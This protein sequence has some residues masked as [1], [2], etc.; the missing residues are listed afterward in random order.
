MHL[1]APLISTVSVLLTLVGATPAAATF[2]GANG[3][4]VFV[5]SRDGTNTNLY[6][7]HLDG[8]GLAPVTRDTDVRNDQPDWSPDGT[9]LAFI[10]NVDSGTLGKYDIYAVQTDGNELAR[11]TNTTSSAG[12]VWSPDGSKLAFGTYRDGNYDIYTMNADGSAPTNITQSASDEVYVTWSP[13][14]EEMAFASN[15]D[16]IPTDPPAQ[17]LDTLD[18]Y[19]MRADGTN[20]RRLTDNT[21]MDTAPDWSPDGRKLAFMRGGAGGWDDVYTLTLSTRGVTRLTHVDGF[22]ENPVWSPDGTQIA[23]DSGR[24]GPAQIYTMNADGSGQTVRT[25]IGEN[26]NPDWQRGVAPTA[27]FTSSLPSA[28]KGQTVIFDGSPSSDLDGAIRQYAWDLDGDGTFETNTGTGAI[29]ARA[30]PAAGSV[31]VGLRVTDSDDNA[32]VVR[33]SQQ[34]SDRPPRASL[35][36]HPNPALT[37]QPVTFDGSS[38][39]DPDGVITDYSWDL[40]GDGTYETHSGQTAKV[41][42]SYGIATTINVKL[43][44]TDSAGTISDVTAFSGHPLVVLR[45]YIRSEAMLAFVGTRHGIR[46][47]SLTLRD[48]PSGARVQIACRT[49][50]RRVCRPQVQKTAARRPEARAAVIIHLI[51]MRNRQLRSGATLEIRITKPGY[52]GR[53]IAYRIRPAAIR[54]IERCMSPGSRSP[55]NACN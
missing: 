29:A 9:R 20:V 19:V 38:S 53:Y 42:R 55:S 51:R 24:A 26:T 48:V 21:V 23:F 15:R 2:P 49:G 35:T 34:V 10:S 30:Y 36:I 37:G 22:D 41:T 43:R 18:L 5:N 50:R 1:R 44:V 16:A 32:V 7:M 28:F 47:R 45:Q 52:V 25:D 12:P 8:A 6:T 54:K 31:N 14:G 27:G 17:P 3:R 40:D 4:I 13:D 39:R 11:L 33:R 46:I